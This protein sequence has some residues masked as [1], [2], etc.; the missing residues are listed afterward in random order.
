MLRPAFLVSLDL[1]R[2]RRCHIRPGALIAQGRLLDALADG[3]SLHRTQA[4]LVLKPSVQMVPEIA[5]ALGVP[6]EDW[7]K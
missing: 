3:G 5:N 4:E 6:M 1:F 2:P 7:V